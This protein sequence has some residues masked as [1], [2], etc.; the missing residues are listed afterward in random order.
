[1]VDYYFII[2]SGSVSPVGSCQRDNIVWFGFGFSTLS[3]AGFFS[4]GYCVACWLA[5][6][7]SD[8]LRWWPLSHEIPTARC[9]VHRQM[10]CTLMAL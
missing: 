7:V 4:V 8:E 5:I 10:E 9:A 2:S 1:M 3:Y 6:V